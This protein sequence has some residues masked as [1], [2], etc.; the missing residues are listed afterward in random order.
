MTADLSAFERAN[1]AVSYLRTSL[2]EGLQKPQVAIV[3]GS[4]LGK[5]ADTIHPES[6]TEYDYAFIPHFPRSTGWLSSLA[7]RWFLTPHSCRTCWKAGLW[8]SRPENS[9]C[10][11]G[12]SCPV[13]SASELLVELQLKLDKLL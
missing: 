8:T 11:D 13:S 4:G 12:W 5:L 9:C 3:C 1:E 6:R 7:E 2:P 10:V